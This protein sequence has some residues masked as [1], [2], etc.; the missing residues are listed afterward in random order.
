MATKQITHVIWDF[1][2]VLIDSEKVYSDVNQMMLSKYGKNFTLK[3]K[4]MMMGRKKSEV[5]N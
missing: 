3:M 1:D 5:I 4:I 2:G